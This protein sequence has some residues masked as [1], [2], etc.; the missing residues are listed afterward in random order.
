MVSDNVKSPIL[1]KITAALLI[2]S[3]WYHLDINAYP[4]TKFGKNAGCEFFT[5][6]CVEPVS[7]ATNG[8]RFLEKFQSRYLTPTFKINFKPFY[9]DPII[10]RFSCLSDYTA[11]AYCMGP[12]NN[13]DT[14]IPSKINYWQNNSYN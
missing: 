9:C 4:D 2:D 10:D 12:S 3:N 8:S 5:K 13:I 11:R 6:P 1:T 7:S 14:T